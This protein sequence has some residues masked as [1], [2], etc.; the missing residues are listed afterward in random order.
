MSIHVMSWVLRNSEEKLGRRLVLLVLADHAKDDGTSAWPSVE[1][2]GREAR[3]SRRQTQANL[4]ALED[5]GAIVSTGTSRHGTTIYTVVMGGANTAPPGAES[6][7]GGRDFLPDDVS[8]TAPEPSEEKPVQ[9][10]PVVP[11][12]AEPPW[13]GKVDRKAV[14]VR[15]GELATAILAEFNRVSNRRFSSKGALT[16]IILRI[17]EHPDVTL[18][19]HAATIEHS[20]RAPWWRGDP[21][22]S[23]VYGN[24]A[25]FE[26]ALNAA[27]AAV[28]GTD[29]GRRILTPEEMD[30]YL[31]EWGPGTPY[32]SLAQARAA[33]AASAER[34]RLEA[35]A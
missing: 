16:K 2:I 34:R 18:A 4:R 15:E 8:K 35:G 27:A 11:A 23:V 13:P 17:R 22:P 9:E 31:V 5:A 14:T 32:E 6:D 33:A 24:D 12:R 10:P 30:T 21:S 3:L 26:R 19:G 7:V 25:L 29:A 1:T 20:F 28:A